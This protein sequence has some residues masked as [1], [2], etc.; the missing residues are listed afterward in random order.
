[1]ASA[2]PIEAAWKPRYNPWLIALTVTIATFMEVLD[3]SIANVALP[4]HCRLGRRLPGRG[5]L[6]TD[7]LPRLLGHHPPHLRLALQ[8]HWPQTL[9][10][11]LRRHV[12][13]LLGALRIRTQSRLAHLCPHSAGPWRWRP[14]AQRTG[15][16]RR[17]LLHREAR[18][19]LRTLRHGRRRRSRDRANARRL[20]HRQ[21]QLA[22]DLLHQPPL[23][24]ALALPLQPHGR[25]PARGHRADQAPRPHRL[26]RPRRRRHRCRPA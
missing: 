12:H 13:R 5:N 7:Q 2:S 1:M 21:L 14:R 18:P 3:T 9:L 20:D 22:L 26:H 19:G 6:G 4:Q 15:Y 8:P 24:P 16:P 25:G 23:R 11:E 17:H 10:H